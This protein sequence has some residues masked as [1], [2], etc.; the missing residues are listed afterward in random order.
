M[1]KSSALSAAV[2]RTRSAGMN[3]ARA[4][5]ASSARAHSLYGDQ[6]FQDS[7]ILLL[8]QPALDGIEA[9]PRDQL[10]GP[11]SLVVRSSFGAGDDHGP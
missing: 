1:S 4:V 3:N 8:Y 11:C 5:P 9:P 7:G 10:H 6:L 2:N